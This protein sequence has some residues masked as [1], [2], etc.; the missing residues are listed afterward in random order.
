MFT[1]AIVSRLP[2]YKQLSWIE[3]FHDFLSFSSL[4]RSRSNNKLLTC[5]SPPINI[6]IVQLSHPQSSSKR[7]RTE[8]SIL[9]LA[10]KRFSFF[11]ISIFTVHENR[12]RSDRQWI[13]AK[14]I[15]WHFLFSF[16]V[17]WEKKWARCGT[18]WF[19]RFVAWS[20]WPRRP[21]LIWTMNCRMVSE[22]RPK[23]KSSF[24]RRH[25]KARNFVDDSPY[26]KA[27][28]SDER[29]AFSRKAAK[30]AKRKYNSLP[31]WKPRGKIFNSQ[32]D[33]SSLTW[34]IRNS[35]SA[36]SVNLFWHG[37][38]F[39]FKA[40]WS[41]CWSAHTYS[42]H[43]AQVHYLWRWIL[44]DSS[45]LQKPFNYDWI[46]LKSFLSPPSAVW[47]SICLLFYG[48][49]ISSSNE[50]KSICIQLTWMEALSTMKGSRWCE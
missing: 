14:H 35:P 29:W 21:I 32:K 2:R 40:Y 13:S 41:A 9:E 49:F 5:N 50:T 11:F 45:I 38:C 20:W 39:R 18:L 12:G 22:V 30:T 3:L 26:G 15:L 6:S 7:Q 19:C 48:T 28:E 47:V 8:T 33:E 27:D 24:R 43:G 16:K 46:Y 1:Q 42:G 10:G 25:E 37:K 44:I 4:S 17:F 36:A 34:L 31:P 23:V